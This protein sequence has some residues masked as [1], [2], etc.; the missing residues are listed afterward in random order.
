MDISVIIPCYNEE[1][2]IATQ[3]DALAAQ[4]WPGEWEII[5]SD[6]GST[7]GTLEIVKKY[8]SSKLPNLI[9]V[10][11]SACRGSPFAVNTGVKIAKGDSLL[12][13]DAD[14]EVGEG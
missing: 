13:C 8:Q 1:K 5:L 10:D 6:N 11:S 3:L 9:I 2:N 12:L 14:D 7:D 4:D